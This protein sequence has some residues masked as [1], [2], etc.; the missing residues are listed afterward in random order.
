MPSNDCGMLGIP[1]VGGATGI[2]GAGAPPA[3][4]VNG[5]V[6]SN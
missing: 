5:V 3:A 1:G 2:D 4:N 6:P